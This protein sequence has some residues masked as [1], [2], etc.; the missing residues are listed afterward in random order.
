[1]T[2]SFSMEAT[3]RFFLEAFSRAEADG[4]APGAAWRVVA[5][6]P[7]L[8]LLDML[9]ILPGNRPVF[10]WL[11]PGERS[12]VGMDVALSVMGQ[13]EQRFRQVQRRIEEQAHAVHTLGSGDASLPLLWFGGFRFDDNQTAGKAVWPT[14][15]DAWFV[16]PRWLYVQDPDG[17]AWLQYCRSPGDKTSQATWLVELQTWLAA[18][19]GLRETAIPKRGG[20]SREV[21]VEETMLWTQWD[22]YLAAIGAAIQQGSVRKVVA[23]RCTRAQWHDPVSVSAIVRSLAVDHKTST[24]FSLGGWG[25]LAPAWEHV[26]FV[27]AT[28]ET[29][30]AKRGDEVYTEALAGTIPPGEGQAMRLL[31]SGKDRAEHDWVVAAIVEKLTPWVDK[32]IYNPIP[33]VKTLPHVLHLHT[34]IRARMRK[35]TSILELVAQLHPTPAV[36]GVPTEPALE[37][38]QRHE[39]IS[40]G[41]Y[42]GPIGWVDQHGDGCFAVG[43]RSAWISPRQAWVFA[44]A[45]IVTGSDPAREYQETQWKQR[46]IMEV[47]RLLS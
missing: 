25:A 44:G 28:P 23:A 45:G 22:G 6:V 17:R 40:R 30:V 36:C 15:T 39:A 4:A 42:A 3:L 31:Q 41:W 14:E 13:G 7:V 29:L 1:M 26:H 19:W 27:G 34:P 37:L 24:C 10:S 21:Q 38:I 43:L 18:C 5:P 32:C 46:V 12:F 35:K 33:A 2:L 8:P 20:P 11:R 9:G 47:I 16:V